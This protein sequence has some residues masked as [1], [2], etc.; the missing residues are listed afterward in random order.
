[1]ATKLYNS[2]LNQIIYNSKQYYILDT[3]ISLVHISSEINGK[4]IIQTYT[5]NKCDLISL[6]KTYVNAS[7]KTISNCI[8]ALFDMHILKFNEELNSWFIVDME[9]MVKPKDSAVN[10]NDN[11]ESYT[12]YTTIREFFLSDE[13]SKLKAREKRVLLHMA[14]LKD[15]KAGKFY[16]DFTMNLLKPKNNWLKVI[17]TN[18]KY[19]AKYTIDKMLTKYPSIFTDNSFGLREKDLSP[20]R[21]KSFKYSIC[22]KVIKKIVI[23]EDVFNLV[24]LKNNKEYHMIKDKVQFANITLSKKLIMHLVRAISNIKEWFIKERVAQIIINKYIAEQIHN[25]PN[26][27]K[28]LPCYAAVVVK[29]VINEY[30][31]FLNVIKRNIKVCN[32]EL[33]DYYSAYVKDEY[34]DSL[35]SKD[36]KEFNRMVGA[37]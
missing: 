33:G 25:H 36:E 26:R 30:R 8:D 14:Q 6:V 15:S 11:S 23:E 1:M 9:N 10:E 2:H 24:V 28:S 34:A 19:Y 22:C 13:F 12:G 4:F 35:S 27:I 21:N 32:Y 7:Y 18:S 29:S 17:R 3:Y 16:D 37:L 31:D 5:D 20:V